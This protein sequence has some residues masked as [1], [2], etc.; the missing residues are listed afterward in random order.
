MSI[1]MLTDFF[2]VKLPCGHCF[3]GPCISE[4][5]VENFENDITCP[6]CRAT[7]C[8]GEALIDST[9]EA[10]FTALENGVDRLPQSSWT[11][12]EAVLM[13]AKT[14]MDGERWVEELCQLYGMIL[15]GDSD[16]DQ[17]ARDK[18]KALVACLDETLAL[19]KASSDKDRA[20]IRSEMAAKYSSRN[21]S[22]KLIMQNLEGNDS[23]EYT[24]NVDIP[25]LQD[26]SRLVYEY[27]LPRTVSELPLPAPEPRRSHSM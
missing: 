17:L 16:T 2:A 15:W 9:G 14:F 10:V 20:K 18:V 25:W 1:V 19:E 13:A 24:K 22:D 4:W 27:Q 3:G 12:D 8:H 7:V 26:L 5:C 6:L 11:C 23:G 21:L